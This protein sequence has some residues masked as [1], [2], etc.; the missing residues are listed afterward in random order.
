[1]FNLFRLSWYVYVIVMFFAVLPDAVSSI[2]DSFI[3]LFV[4]S[5]LL[6]IPEV[7]NNE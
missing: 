3:L 2:E 1:M 5:F 6:V 7:F 4:T